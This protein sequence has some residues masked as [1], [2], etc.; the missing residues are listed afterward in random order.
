MTY[1]LSSYLLINDE[2]LHEERSKIYRQSD[3]HEVKNIIIDDTPPY[4]KLEKIQNLIIL[5]NRIFEVKA[6]ICFSKVAYSTSN[7][8]NPMLHYSVYVLSND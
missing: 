2:F 1:E 3:K 6:A 4:S 7:T 5:G 8:S